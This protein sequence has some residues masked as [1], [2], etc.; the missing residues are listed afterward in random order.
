MKVILLIMRNDEWKHTNPSQEKYL[1]LSSAVTQ[2]A[3]CG[4]KS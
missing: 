2:F 3:Y 4:G 1:T